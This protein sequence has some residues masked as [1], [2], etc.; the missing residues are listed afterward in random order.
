M[1]AIKKLAL[2]LIAL[3]VITPIVPAQAG[4][5]EKETSL[6]VD[7]QLNSTDW[8][9]A[10]DSTYMDDGKLILP[11]D[12]FGRTRVI[13]KNIAQEDAVYETMFTI[14]YQAQMAIR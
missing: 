7:G 12:G 3:L 8:F 4:T 1:K 6:L 5:V 10:E 13:S 11:A 9:D 2:L 14:T